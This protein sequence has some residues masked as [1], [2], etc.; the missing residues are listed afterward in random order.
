MYRACEAGQDQ[1]TGA[2]H[3]F[4]RKRG[5]IHAELVYPAHVENRLSRLELWNAA[6]FSESRKNSVT[7]REIEVSLPCEL[8]RQSQLQ[9]ARDFAQLIAEKHKVA[10]DVCV[11]EPNPKGDQR[12]V[13]A[14]LLMTTRRVE[15]DC[16]FGSKTRE[17][18]MRQSGAVVELREAWA[19]CCN[20]Q[21]EQHMLPERVSHL[22]LLE[23]GLT[24]EPEQH[25]GPTATAMERRG[26]EP[27]RARFMS[28]SECEDPEQHKYKELEE[29]KKEISDGVTDWQQAW[30]AEKAMQEQIQLELL[31]VKQEFEQ[32]KMRQEAVQ[33]EREIREQKRER[34]RSRQHDFEM[35]M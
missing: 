4:T 5:L 28:M 1:R 31:R 7:A 21:L 34:V 18:D 17:L 29:A 11:H 2:D 35:E 15:T 26:A 8:P 10:V 30:E 6:E 9:L 25:M 33:R 19:E 20:R 23:Q 13:H 24:R 14:H 12:N 27:D 22:S 32:E 16:T 3:D